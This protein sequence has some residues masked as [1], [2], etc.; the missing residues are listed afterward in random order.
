M[1]TAV[2]AQLVTGL[3]TLIIGAVLVFQLRT[4]NQQIAIQNR[5]L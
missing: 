1:D 4:Q 2:I 3:A 5:Q